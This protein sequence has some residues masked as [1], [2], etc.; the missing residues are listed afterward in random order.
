MTQK[1][2]KKR[3]KYYSDPLAMPPECDPLC[4]FRGCYNKGEDK[5]TFSPGRGYT[6]YYKTF[7]PACM[8][9]LH[10][11]CRGR[12]LTI[13]QQAKAVKWAMGMLRS[14]RKLERQAGLRVMDALVLFLEELSEP[15]EAEKLDIPGE[16]RML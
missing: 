10:H 12:T 2:Q 6:S 13:G 9:R 16:R 11:G 3:E 5:G 14:T 7:N 8:Q 1:E 4:R 15:A